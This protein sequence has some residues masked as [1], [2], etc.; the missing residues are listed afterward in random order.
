[1]MAV[2]HGGPGKEQAR[3]TSEWGGGNSQMEVRKT[4]LA[5]INVGR[6]RGKEEGEW[7]GIY[8]DR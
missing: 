5:E 4:K 7:G 2:W 1:M 6:E 8:R 3:H